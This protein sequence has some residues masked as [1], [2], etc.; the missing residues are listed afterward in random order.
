[1][2]CIRDPFREIGI[3]VLRAGTYDDGTLAEGA[4]LVAA[5]QDVFGL[6][7]TSYLQ[8]QPPVWTPPDRNPQPAPTRRLLETG[9]RDPATTLDPAALAALPADAGL[10]LAVGEQPAGLA[11]NYIPTTRVGG[12]AYSEAGTSDPEAQL[13]KG[14]LRFEL[15]GHKLKGGWHLVRSGKPARPPQWLRFGLY[16]RRHEEYSGELEKFHW[17]NNVSLA[18]VDRDDRVVWEAGEGSSAIHDPMN[19]VERR[20]ANLDQVIDNLLP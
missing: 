8:P 4:I 19:A 11:L 6:P 9:Y 3:L 7:A 12:G 17:A 16:E 5:V 13:A 20:A 2:F 10:V 14:H 1:M 18:L 15:F